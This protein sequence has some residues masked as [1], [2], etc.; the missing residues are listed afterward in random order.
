MILVKCVPGEKLPETL[1]PVRPELS[2]EQAL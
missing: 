1:T 2:K